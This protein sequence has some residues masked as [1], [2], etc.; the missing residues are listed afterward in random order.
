MLAVWSWHA[1]SPLS[2]DTHSPPLG[3]GILTEKAGKKDTVSAFQLAAHYECLLESF[4]PQ[5]EPPGLCSERDI[6]EI[7][8]L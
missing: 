6:G 5:L 1:V 2:R 7:S 3:F 8:F 4:E